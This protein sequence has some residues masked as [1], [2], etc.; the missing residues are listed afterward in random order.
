MKIYIGHD[1]DQSIA[2][3]VCE[4]SIHKYT[5]YPVHTER[6]DISELRNTGAYYRPD[7]SPASTEFTYTRFLV[8]YLNDYKGWAMF[9]DSDFLF[10]GDVTNMWDEYIM[11]DPHQDE[12]AVYCVKHMHYEPKNDTKFWGMKQHSFPRKNWSSLMIFNCSHPSVKKLTPLTIAN[13]SPQWLHR[14]GWCKDEEIGYISYKW[15]W[16][17]GEYG[18]SERMPPKA[19]HFTNGGPWNDVW[20]QDY[21]E[22]WCAT[23]FEMTGN[24]F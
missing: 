23:Y 19:L 14:F 11:S 4:F 13:Q 5:K 21:E 17:V 12:T 2:T 1:R 20:G 24:I 3:D 16:L 15:N 18:K 8:P 6:L 9:V 22:Y 10:A 7:G